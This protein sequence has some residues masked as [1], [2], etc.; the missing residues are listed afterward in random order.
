M[1][2]HISA[3]ILSA[4]FATLGEDVFSVLKAGADSI[5][6]DVM[7]NHFVPNLTMGPDI[8]SDLRGFGITCPIHVHLMT[9]NIDNLVPMFASAGATSIAFH[10]EISPQNIL[11]NIALIQDYGCSVGVALNPETDISLVTPLL[12]IIN[13]V[14]VMSVKPGFGGQK[15]LPGTYNKIT[16]LYLAIEKRKTSC[17]I[18]VDGGVNLSNISQLAQC[19]ANNF[20]VGSALFGS[21]NYADEICQLRADLPEE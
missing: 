8:C 5:H 18:Y 19:G 2:Y 13:Y 7:D 16:E 20:V 21:D 14:V 6:F 1:P 4:N 3:S 11:Q 12:S 9:S 17:E 10:P 15:L